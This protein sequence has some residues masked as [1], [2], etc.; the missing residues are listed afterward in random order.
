MISPTGHGRR[1]IDNWG[2]G[3]YGAGRGDHLHNG[4]DYIAF[5]GQDVYMPI[6]H[7][8]II[9]VKSPYAGYS[10]LLIRNA[11]IE[12]TL[13]YVDPI[14]GLIGSEVEQGGV[15][16]IAQDIGEKYPGIIPH[17]HLHIDS[18]DPELLINL[19]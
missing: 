18:I 17:V 2:S 11:S 5:P 9:R 6:K 1:N 10:G 19:P 15:I 3:A 8:K 16:G 14:M 13:F 7:G 12:L 4:A